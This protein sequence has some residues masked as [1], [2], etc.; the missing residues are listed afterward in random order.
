MSCCGSWPATP[1]SNISTTMASPS[2]TNGPTRM[3]ISARSTASSGAPGRM[4]TAAPIDQI[5]NLLNE[6]AENPH[7]RR[8]IVSAWNPAEVD[9]MALPPCHC[10]FQ[11]YVAGRQAVL[12]A[13]PALGRHLPRRAVQHR[14]LRAADADGGAG[15]RAEARRFHPH[16]RRCASLFEPFRAGARAACGARPR[17]CRRCGSIR[18]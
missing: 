4:A 10:L 7:S 6:I 8:L 5:A 11:F 13:L 17:R 1:T 18:R 16:A 3:A 15:D 9:A 12:P 2:G 14:L